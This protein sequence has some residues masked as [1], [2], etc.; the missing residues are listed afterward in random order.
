MTYESHSGTFSLFVRVDGVWWLI[1]KMDLDLV[2]V[3]VL[4]LVCF[5]ILSK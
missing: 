1:G 4:L 2:E 3:C 5:V